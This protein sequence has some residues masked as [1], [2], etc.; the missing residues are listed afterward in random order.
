MRVRKSLYI[1]IITLLMT[2][3]GPLQ[4][5]TASQLSEKNNNQPAT[6]MRLPNEGR[7][8]LQ[9]LIQ[10]VDA[11][12]G[13][14]SAEGKSSESEV[15][16]HEE[17]EPPIEDSNLPESE[18]QGNQKSVVKAKAPR[19][20]TTNTNG[21]STWT[22]D[23]ANSLLVFGAGT[24]AERIDNNLT[25]A[26]IDPTTVINIQFKSGVVAPT[27]VT[28]LFANLTRLSQ[29]IDLSH[30]DTSSVKSMAYWFQQDSAL[31]T[32]DL[33]AFNTSNVTNLTY[34][35]SGSGVTSL[36][37]SSWDVTKVTSFSNMF[38]NAT[39]LTTL[40][41]STWGVERTATMVD[42]SYMFKDT[43][44][45][46]NLNLTDFKTT[47]VTNMDSMFRGTDVG[48][49]NKLVSLDLSDWDVTKV[50]RFSEMFR[51]TSN[52]AT[53][54]LSTWG[55]GRTATDVTML[56]MFHFCGTTNID[57]DLTDF[58]TTNVTNMAQM[59]RSSRLTSLD[60]SS[61]DVTKVSL[62]EFM[63]YG[64]RLMTLNLA[65]WG[66]GRTAYSVSMGYMFA[67]CGD[68]NLNLTNFKTSNVIAMECM[69]GESRLT[70]LDLSDRDV[71]KVQY[72]GRM[73]YNATNLTS[74]NLSTWGVGRTATDVYMYQMFSGT[75]SLTN[76]NLTNFKTTNVTDMRHMFYKTGLTSL[77]L[78]GWDVTKV[79]DFDNM[80][81]E[82]SLRILNL[83]GWHTTGSSVFLMFYNTTKLWKITLGE[84]IKF[85][86]NPKFTAAPAIGT[87]IPG[88][89]YKTTAASWQIVGS[90]T[91]YYPQGAMVTTTE[92]YANR[93]E[94]TTYVWANQSVQPT[95]AI[96]TISSLTF[97][98][99]GASDFFN[100]N[101]PLATNMAT[102]LVSLKHLDNS[103]TYNVT[104][105]QTSDWTTDGESATIAKSNLKI[106]YGA[107]D[108]STGA[109]SFWSGT[110]ATATKSIAFNHDDTKNF[111]IWLNPSTVLDTALLG[112]QLESELT[113]TLSETP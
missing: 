22:F 36:D 8:D 1:I 60:L 7:S 62:F 26:G 80:F 24:L 43:V 28:Y 98:T 112:K 27:A 35:F 50:T 64:S 109:C 65:N 9:E 56:G 54:N 104:V 3:S 61:W 105:A 107:N 103:T 95:P 69:F 37:F 88:T 40:N 78:S 81:D 25:N 20:I 83:S 14:D 2:L 34:M 74:L 102:G 82:S 94:P 16:E 85:A 10:R 17:V 30:F 42:M 38:L 59:F 4:A 39:K 55:V 72:F 18:E 76:L 44:N 77:D 33:S 113:W 99:L 89:S 19:A 31:A 32:P 41:L 87:T 106:K 66:V 45:L 23:S 68:I 101:S 53:L 93:T 79:T 90:G 100:G 71:T 12:V 86:E 57:I 97:G 91:D 15:D 6:T 111:S 63:F 5:V 73:F 11:N 21:T 70:S 96:N 46:T 75:S 51:D 49:G 67:A 47:N 13:D 84:D 48:I 52:L 58:K 29:L 108:L 92:M 110:S